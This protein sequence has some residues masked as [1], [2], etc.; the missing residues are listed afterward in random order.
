MMNLDDEKIISGRIRRW[1]LVAEN[2]VEVSD[3]EAVEFGER[4]YR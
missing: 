3:S 4:E 1:L 2:T